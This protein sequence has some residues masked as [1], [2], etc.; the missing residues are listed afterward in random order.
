MIP[1][2]MQPYFKHLQIRSPGY[3]QHYAAGQDCTYFLF[4]QIVVEPSISSLQ[5]KIALYFITFE[6]NPNDFVY[7]FDGPSI[8][9]PLIA[10]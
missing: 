2:R 3:P 9:S 5:H 7:I 4:D 1:R 6:T 8:Q 10:R